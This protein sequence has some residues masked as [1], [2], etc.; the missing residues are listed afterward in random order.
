MP[1]ED[2]RYP[3]QRPVTVMISAE[4]IADRLAQLPTRKEL[5]RAVLLGV[6][7][8]ACLVQCLAWLFHA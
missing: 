7:T 4:G 6:T 8:G 1:D 3:N 2:H 5:Y